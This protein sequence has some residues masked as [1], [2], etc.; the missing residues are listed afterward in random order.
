MNSYA[1]ELRCVNCYAEYPLNSHMYE[2]CPSCR[3]ERFASSLSPTYDYERLRQSVSRDYF[4]QRR[5]EVGVWKY[6]ELLPIQEAAHRVTLAE[7][8]TPLVRCERWARELGLKGIYV[9]DES[10][11]PTWSFKDRHSA[12]ATSMALEQGARTVTIATSGNNGASVAA[13][14]AKAGIEAV[15]FTF[16][17]YYE[18]ITTLMRMYGAYVFVTDVEGRWTLMREGIKRYGWHPV[19]NLTAIPTLN[20]YGHEGYKT[21]A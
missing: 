5:R 6:S 1:L 4:S 18:T 17:G 15:I 19:G 7:G 8:A 13:Y 12:V 3:T 16:P 21:I 14:A 11:N 9:K 10:R 20:P 2:G